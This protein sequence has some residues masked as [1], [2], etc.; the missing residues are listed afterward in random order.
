M[1]EVLDEPV[2]RSEMFLN[3]DHGAVNGTQILDPTLLA[4]AMHRTPGPGA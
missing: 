4:V 2:P 3:N 1:C